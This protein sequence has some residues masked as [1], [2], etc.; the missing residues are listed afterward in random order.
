MSGTVFK[1][2]GAP[3]EGAGW[4]DSIPPPPSPSGPPVRGRGPQP[5]LMVSPPSTGRATP[6]MNDAAGSARLNVAW[7]TSSGS[8]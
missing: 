2:V 7:A 5:V 3:E 1:T 8:P 4:F 6:L